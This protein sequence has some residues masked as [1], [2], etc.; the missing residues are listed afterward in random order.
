MGYAADL[1]L[2]SPYAYT[3]SKNLTLENL[4]AWAKLKGLDLLACGDFTHPVWLGELRRKLKPAGPGLYRFNGVHFV[5]G[6]E[7][8]CNYRQGSRPRR[9]HLLLFAPD[10]DTVDRLNLALA[11][12]NNRLESNG[13]PNLGMS[14][15]DLTA[16]ALEISTDCMVIPA[17]VWTP[18]FGLFGSK[19]G[20]DSLEECFRDLTPQIHALETGLS[21]DPA[22][23]WPI[24]ELDEKTIVSFSDAHSPPKL[25]R[26]LTVF[27]GELSY[28]GLAEALAHQR[29]AFTAEFYPQEGKYH[30]DGHRKCGVRQSPEDTR[31]QG[32]RCLVCRRPLTLGVANQAQTM[33][34]RGLETSGVSEVSGGFVRH[35]GHRPPFIRLVPL[36]EI[37]AETLGQGPSTKRVEAE[38]RRISQEL[39]N[40]L[41]VLT[42]AAAADLKQVAGERLAQAVLKARLGDVRIDPGYDGIYGKVQVWPDQPTRSPN[43]NLTLRKG[44]RTSSFPFG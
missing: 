35:A 3:C 31:R 6:T 28:R 40:E 44:E 17:H 33:A 30:S 2:H 39:G 43:S 4:T 37:I 42:S 29:V 11:A 13:R 22:M 26:E 32:E 12:R 9:V 5:L 16:L 1:H 18:W 19:S 27:E 10:F 23:F 15:R 36:R 7:V 20:F 38:Y 34:N 8:C 41:H 25:G 21:S 14:A 24:A